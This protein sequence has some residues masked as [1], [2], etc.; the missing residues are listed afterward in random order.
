MPKVI[1]E[2]KEDAKRRIIEAAIDVIAEQ[3]SDKM[4][5]D[6]VAK[7]LGVTKGAVYWYFKTKED[8]CSAV[9]NKIQT[10]MQKVEFESYYNRSLEETLAQMYD[11]FSLNDD[12]QRAIFF[13]MFAMA[14]R[15]SDVRHATRE[16]Y[17]GL[18]S[19]F[20]SVIKKKKRQYFLQ[21]QTDDRKLALL[22]VAL[23][24]GLKNY[25]QVYMYQNEV[26]DLWLEGIKILLKTSYTGSYGEKTE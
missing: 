6:D 5:I 7:K 3:G 26:R 12:R 8:L 20:E 23:Y 15:N 2:Y 13:E 10:D 11:R 19:T 4:R 22:M 14:S 17:N 21:T 9:L 1:P 18:V 16:Y 25:E 24:S